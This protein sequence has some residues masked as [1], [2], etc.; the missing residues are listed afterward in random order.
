[1][2]RSDKFAGIPRRQLF[3]WPR[4]RWAEPW[5]CWSMNGSCS[6]LIRLLIRLFL[7]VLG[8][9]RRYVA[10][11]LR[12]SICVFKY[13][14]EWE[15]FVFQYTMILKRIPFPYLLGIKGQSVGMLQIRFSS[16]NGRK[17][18]KARWLLF[19]F[20]WRLPAGPKNHCASVDSASKALVSV[21]AVCKFRQIVFASLKNIITSISW[22]MLQ[23]TGWSKK[24]S[25]RF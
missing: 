23:S 22:H 25:F 21:G 14:L 10:E 6:I 12:L 2:S 18:Q 15:I 5:N 20:V 3:D 17:P 4:T 24:S 13:F 9:F 1:M 19:K 16:P 11:F 7:A 8:T